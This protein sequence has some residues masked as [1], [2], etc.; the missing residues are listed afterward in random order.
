MP[1][2][3]VYLAG[4][5]RGFPEFNFPAFK[6]AA[7]KLRSKGKIVFNPAE[8]DIEEFGNIIQA[9]NPKGSEKVAAKKLGMTGLELARNCFLRDTD[10]ICR[11]ADAV[12]LMPG[13]SKS[14]GAKA[15]KALAEAIGLKV[16]KLRKGDV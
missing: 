10:W 3:Y 9:P 1:V 14:R 4:P 13:W 16:I 8:E 11:Y 6:R 5:M 15:E 2:N 7:A 12:A